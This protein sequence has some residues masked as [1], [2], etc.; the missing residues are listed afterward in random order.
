MKYIM[1]SVGALFS[2]PLLAAVTTTAPVTFNGEVSIGV[3][4]NS[5][6]S[7]DEL[8]EV[9][10]QAD[11][12]IEKN[13]A[14][15][16]V[17]QVNEQAKISTS[18][19]FQAQDYNEFDAF[20]LSLHQVSVDASYKWQQKALGLRY[21]GAKAILAG[22]RFL[23]F[24]QAS[25][26]LGTYLQPSTFLRT[27]AKVKRKQF[28]HVTDRDADAYGANASLF[29]F[30]NDGKTMF[31]LAVSAD[32]ENAVDPQFSHYSYGVNTKFSQKFTALGFAQTA[33]LAWRFQS[34]DFQSV[35]HEQLSNQQMS[36]RDEH[37]HVF[38]AQWQLAF[39]RY[40]ALESQLEYGDYRSQLDSQTYS[41]TKSSLAIKA[42]F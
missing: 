12:G 4:S 37:Q 8:D 5:A 6:L 3:I 35:S 23:T 20:D 32:K 14:V 15:A 9:S 36:S 25:M 13:A 2:M 16:G 24:Q 7:I 39:N 26:Y 1:A 30:I 10:S 31:M 17:W 28:A 19:R 38:Q 21:D 34:K 33:A 22:E 29:H 18:Y 40:L 11:S 27:S 41:Q 42:K